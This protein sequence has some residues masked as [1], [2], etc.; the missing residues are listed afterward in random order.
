MIEKI[1]AATGGGDCGGLNAVLE[2]IARSAAHVGWNVDIPKKGWEGFIFDDRIPLRPHDVEG[3]HSM[4]GTIAQTSRTNPYN[5]TG[6]L[7]GEFLENAN[8]SGRVIENIK[9]A[10]I[11]G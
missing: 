7:D 8:V 9:K 4:T 1:A 11:G 5:F 2:A 6:E 3:I 10:G